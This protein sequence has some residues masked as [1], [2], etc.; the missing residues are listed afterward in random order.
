MFHEALVIQGE[1]QT[2]KVKNMSY[3]RNIVVSVKKQ[4]P[5]NIVTHFSYGENQKKCSIE[6]NFLLCFS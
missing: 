3:T 5:I 6:T 1:K 4:I 2:V